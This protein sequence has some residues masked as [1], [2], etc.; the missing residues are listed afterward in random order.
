MFIDAAIIDTLKAFVSRYFS[1]AVKR[2]NGEELKV[3]VM[4]AFVSPE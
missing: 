3:P 2:V 4:D 1:V